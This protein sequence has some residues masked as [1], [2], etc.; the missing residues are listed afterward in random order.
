M[1]EYSAAKTGEYPRIFP[2]FQNCACMKILLVEHTDA[3]AC[4]MKINQTILFTVA[5]DLAFYSLSKPESK[6]QNLFLVKKI[7]RI[8]NTIASILGENMLG[9]LS[10]D[11]ICSSRHT[12]FLELRSRKTVH[13]SNNVCGQISKHIFAPNGGYCLYIERDG[14][15]K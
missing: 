10:L 8:I 5:L 3:T 12:V 7:W 14:K 6:S 4:S 1:T 15:C 11:I 9:Y 2:N 13:F